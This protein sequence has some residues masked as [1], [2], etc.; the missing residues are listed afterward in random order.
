MSPA[1]PV[2]LGGDL[3]PPRLGHGQS[4]AVGDH[5]PDTRASRGLLDRPDKV[6][7]GGSRSPGIDENRRVQQVLIS[8]RVGVT[9]Q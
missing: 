3:Q 4:G 8:N 2:T 5:R 9:D 7:A 1:L 6:G